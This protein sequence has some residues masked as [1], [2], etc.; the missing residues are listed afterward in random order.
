[1]A[2]KKQPLRTFGLV[3]PLIALA[4]AVAMLRRRRGQARDHTR[5]TDVGF[6][7]AMHDALRRDIARV[8]RLVAVEDTR[9]PSAA[10]S[11]QCSSRGTQRGIPTCLPRCLCRHLHTSAEMHEVDRMVEEHAALTGAIDAVDGALACGGD[12][13]EVVADLD[14]AL[15]GHLDHEERTVL[16]LLERHLTQASR[17]ACRDAWVKATTGRNDIIG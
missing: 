13:K 10:L 12:R 15:Q 7:R 9:E 8:G 2:H 4:V 16:P 6:M 11:Q 3:L 1:M 14:R 17:R 5:Q